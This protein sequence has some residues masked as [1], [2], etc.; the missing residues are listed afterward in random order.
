MKKRLYRC[1]KRD[2]GERW[3]DDRELNE[4]SKLTLYGFIFVGQYPLPAAGLGVLV[5]FG[6]E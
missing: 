4:L 5:A 1:M 3:I 2:V 6:I